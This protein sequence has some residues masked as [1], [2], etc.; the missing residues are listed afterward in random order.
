MILNLGCGSNKICT[1]INID[2]NQD[3]KPDMV[4]DFKSKLPFPDESAEEVYLFH[5]I[6]HIEKIHH[7]KVLCE[8]HRVLKPDGLVIISYPE[9]IRCAQNYIDNYHGKRDFWEATIYGRQ[10]YKSDYHVA[11]MNSEEFRELL[12]HVGF[13]NIKFKADPDG[14][15]YTVAYALKG[16]PMI[17]YEQVLY[18]NVFKN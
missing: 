3:L 7:V 13:Y 17:G 5:T 10:L 8:I 1:A 16:E 6:E 11:L 9:F 18:E 14:P 12:E 4:A 2:I 15:H